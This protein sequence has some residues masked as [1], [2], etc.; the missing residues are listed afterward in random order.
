MPRMK[1]EAEARSRKVRGHRRSRIRIPMVM[2]TA[3]LVM[4][5]SVPP[6]HVPSI[7]CD[8]KTNAAA[9]IWPGSPHSVKK[10]EAKHA[11]I[12]RGELFWFFCPDKGRGNEECYAAD[13][14]CQVRLEADDGAAKNHCNQHF[15]PAGHSK[16][17]E[18]RTGAKAERE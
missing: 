3:P 12:P 9:E 15:R 10:K 1:H 7:M 4:M 8:F 6:S 2:A 13:G 5:A 16:R 17:Q 18:H 14:I 11:S